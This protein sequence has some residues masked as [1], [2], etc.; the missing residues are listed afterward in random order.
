MKTIHIGIVII[1]IIVVIAFIFVL[2]KERFTNSSTLCGNNGGSGCLSIID[3]DTAVTTS[4]EETAKSLAINIVTGDLNASTSIPIGGVIMWAGTV[5]PPDGWAICDGRTVSQITTPD[6]RGR[7]I[8]GAST[9]TQQP[10]TVSSGLSLYNVGDFGGAEVH[11]LTIGEMP[12]HSH[13]YSYG[14]IGG[15]SGTGNDWAAGTI[16]TGVEGKSQPHN[17]LPPF[18][19]LVYIM[20][21]Q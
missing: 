17:N 13:S 6:L 11:T 10:P 15:D 8:I 21:V 2:K 4:F 19:A 3:S 12:A 7:F 5:S 14:A 18:Y 16:E 20:K 1:V 9:Y